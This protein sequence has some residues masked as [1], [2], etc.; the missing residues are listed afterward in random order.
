MEF[1]PPI[2]ERYELPLPTDGS[3][4]GLLGDQLVMEYDFL[5]VVVVTVD[6]NGD[7]GGVQLLEGWDKTDDCGGGDHAATASVKGAMEGGDGAG[8][9]GMLSTG[10]IGA[11]DILAK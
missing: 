3:F 6:G 10:L 2:L 9:G 1:V 11:A 8:A 5:A 4:V 7:G